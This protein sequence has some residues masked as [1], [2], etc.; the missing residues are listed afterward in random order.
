[1]LQSLIRSEIFVVGVEGEDLTCVDF[2]GAIWEKFAFSK[3]SFLGNNSEEKYFVWRFGD[4][5]KLEFKENR[6]E[7]G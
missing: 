4:S 1:M 7:K 2:L 5:Q 6:M 3:R